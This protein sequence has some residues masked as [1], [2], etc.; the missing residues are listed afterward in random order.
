MKY[1]KL[2]YTLLASLLLAQGEGHTAKS[3]FK[4]Q[5]GAGYNA[6]RTKTSSSPVL[7][8]GETL[9]TGYRMGP[10]YQIPGDLSVFKTTPSIDRSKPFNYQLG[11]EITLHKDSFLKAADKTL[12]AYKVPILNISGLQALV[13]GGL[14]TG[15]TTAVILGYTLLNNYWNSQPYGEI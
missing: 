11:K 3:S 4:D 13:G 6:S 14:I 7:A 5:I 1:N 15:I 12:S 10:S 2:T 9:P 8:K